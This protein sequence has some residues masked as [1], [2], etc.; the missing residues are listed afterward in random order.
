MWMF[1]AVAA[2]AALIGIG[3]YLLNILSGSTGDEPPIRV[4]RGLHRRSS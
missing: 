2:T 4:K 1:A 3:A